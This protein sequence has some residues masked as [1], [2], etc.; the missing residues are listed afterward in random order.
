MTW[1]FDPIHH[2]ALLRCGYIVLGHHF[3]LSGSYLDTQ[4]ALEPPKKQLPT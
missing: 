3:G 4:M 1:L 2:Q